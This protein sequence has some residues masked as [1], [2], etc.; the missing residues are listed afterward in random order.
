MLLRDG[1]LPKPRQWDKIVNEPLEAEALLAARVSVKR[2][3]PFG[4]PDWVRRTVD[5]LGLNFTLRERGRPKNVEE[6]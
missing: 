3:R 4:A 2:G 5:R 1:P 6:R